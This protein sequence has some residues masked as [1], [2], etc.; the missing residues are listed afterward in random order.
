MT[1]KGSLIHFEHQ[2]TESGYGSVYYTKNACL[3][4]SI[5]DNTFNGSRNVG[6][7]VIR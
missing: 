1:V 7:R 4:P 5:H 6:P 3:H 2:I